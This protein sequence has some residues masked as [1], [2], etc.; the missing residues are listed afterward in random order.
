MMKLRTIAQ[1]TLGLTLVPFLFVQ[2]S[3]A[4]GADGHRM[5]NFLAAKNLPADVPAFL[6][7]ADAQQTME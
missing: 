5:I 1:A 4:W 3:A 2:R 7:D 6:R